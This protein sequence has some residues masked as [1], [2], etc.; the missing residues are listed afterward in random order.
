MLLSEPISYWQ[1]DV[2]GTLFSTSLPSSAD[3]VV[4]GGGYLGASVCYWLA[5]AGADVVLLERDFPASGASG[6]NGGF[7]SVG[8]TEAYP[9]AIER[10]GNQTAKE[11]LQVT[12]ESR[13]L[14]RQVLAEEEIECDYRE[15]GHLTLALDETQ[16][17]ALSR[18]GAMLQVDGITTHLLGRDDVQG[19]IG[20][21]LG[22][23][24]VGGLFM[25][26]M[27]L[28]HPV[29]LV[30]G[31]LKAAQQYGVSLV[32]ATVFRLVP[33]GASVMVQTSQGSIHAQQA[34]VATNA[35]T[36]DLL[37]QFEPVVVPVRGQVLTYEPLAPLFQVGL[38]VAM[39]GTEEYWQ[40]APD[41]TIILGGGRA[42]APKHD[43]GVWESLPTKEV[44]QTLEQV[45]PR[46]FPSLSGLR[47]LQRWAGLM[48]FTP[49]Y[50]PIADQ[51]PEMQG[52]WVVGGF[53][54]RGM[55][56]G[57]RLGNLLADSLLQRR[58]VEALRPFRLTRPTLH[59][60]ESV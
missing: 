57:M 34:I 16:Q 36:Q 7:I 18:H 51:V 9:D 5:Q 24:I 25:P 21:A 30:R 33:D 8:P 43:V 4:I 23:D 58:P 49:D 19:M 53:S 20:T 15:C 50:L 13:N 35:W 32:N 28:V 44:Q 56:F 59:Y 3:C 46:L 2:D 10:L 60:K 47:V 45:F 54:G 11:V 42:A 31:L 52:V 37:P 55:P 29:R 26:E 39:T 6:R 27:A 14:L 17:H 41:G 40:Q 38:S 22:L 12:L 1:K 48:A